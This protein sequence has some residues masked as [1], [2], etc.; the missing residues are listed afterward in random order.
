MICVEKIYILKLFS[1]VDSD[2]ASI[3]LKDVPNVQSET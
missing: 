3:S 2:E 1:C